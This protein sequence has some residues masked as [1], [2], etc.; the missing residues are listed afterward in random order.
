MF[1][2]LLL[3][4]EGAVAVLT[5]NR[6]T[7][8]NALNSSTLDDLRRAA[9]HLRDDAAVRAVVVTG[10]GNR[11]FVAGADLQELQAA[12][13]AAYARRGQAAFDALARLGKPSIAAINGFALGGGLE[14]AMACTIR[15]AAAT[16]VLG[17]PEV[18][19]GL[20]PGFGG[21]QRLPRL[22]GEGRALDLLLTGRRL[23]AE[24]ACRIGLVTRVTPPDD[25]Q[26]DALALAETLATGAEDA[27][28]GVM[29]A[30]ACGGESAL[31]AGLRLEADLFAAVAATGDA[32]EGIRAFIEKRAPVFGVARTA[33]RRQGRD[34]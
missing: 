26:R 19:L 25:L 5:V 34:G 14:L 20:M 12:A 4:R 29:M 16:A 11:A 18:T 13:G 17:F 32:R 30:V 24:E 1:E 3:T 21:T 22:V 23:D 9:L 31:P 7:V 8:L 2:N 6:P 28:A 15:M 27:V 10:A 33:G